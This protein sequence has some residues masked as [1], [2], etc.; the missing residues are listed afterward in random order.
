[1]SRSFRDYDNWKLRSPEDEA[2]ERERRY[3]R[4]QDD[5]DSADERN[6]QAQER[7]RIA[8]E[9]KQESE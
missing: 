2:D 8:A 1:M 7:R 3:K 6:E 5:E 4:N 9:S